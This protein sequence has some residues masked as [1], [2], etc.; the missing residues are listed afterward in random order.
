MNAG[1]QMLR[2]KPPRDLRSIPV[3]NCKPEP[4]GDRQNG[5]LHCFSHIFTLS[6]NPL[7]SGRK[8]AVWHRAFTL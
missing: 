3:S 2:G 8:A 1:I 4:I 6:P 5:N 7:T